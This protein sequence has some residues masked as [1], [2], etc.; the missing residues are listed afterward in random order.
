MSDHPDV[1]DLLTEDHR[2]MAGLLDQPDAVDDPAELRSLYLRIVGD[3][4][5]HEAST[6]PLT[7]AR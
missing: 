4:S 7:E 2:R 5:A 3:L 1:I 6:H